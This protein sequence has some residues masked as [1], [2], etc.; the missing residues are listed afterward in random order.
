ML[1]EKLQKKFA[2]PFI[3]NLGW[4][5]ASELVNRIF[6]LGVVVVLARV[7]SAYDYG[8]TAI[9][10]TTSEFILIFTLKTGI[11][12]KLVQADEQDIAVLSQTAYW[13]NWI[14]CIALFTVQ[15]LLAWP[16]AWFYQD[17]R[18][19]APICAMALVYLLMP[20]FTVQTAL[21]QRENRLN[22]IALC[23]VSQSIVGN[24]L[25][26]IFALM[27]FGL[28]S[29]VL[30]GVLVAP[31]WLVISVMNHPWKPKG[32]FTLHRWREIA[33]FAVDVMGIEF[34]GKLRAN[35]DY[36]L[37]GRF[38]GL[39]ALGLYYF[40]FNAG[41]GV[42]LNIINALANSIFPYLC[43]ARQNLQQLSQRYTQGLKTTAKVIV[44][45][46]LLQASLAPFYVPL[47][48]GSQWGMAIPIFVLICLSAIPRPFG[49][50][51]SML[52]QAVDQTRINLYWN[53]GFTVIFAI[54]LTL[55]VQA[56]ILWVAATVLLVH[57]IMLPLFTIGVT[58]HVL[59]PSA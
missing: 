13:M 32:R 46:V 50:V 1:T 30:P 38:L 40:A 35:L 29:L 25:T 26:V 14:L 31:L 10:L 6:R 7:L 48:Y 24:T 28:W 16:I 58:R 44:P 15:C 23:T 4:L 17:M 53:L 57:C 49:E 54:A 18:I 9:V 22:I 21:L 19:V 34:L 2:N 43:D 20:I 56:G 55:S 42:S 47:L 36:L 51:A 59:K 27:G 12:S 3:R 41:L 52:L 33:G 37:I 39:E 11:S 8:L 45:F 5:S